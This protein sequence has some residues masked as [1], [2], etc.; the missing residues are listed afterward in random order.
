MPEETN[1]AKFRAWRKDAADLATE[2]DDLTAF[3]AF[4]DLEDVFEP[5]EQQVK[6]LARE[7]DE[8]IQLQIDI[9]RGK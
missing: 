1:K 4:A 6:R 9:A 5:I 3:A 8:E 2:T 7:V